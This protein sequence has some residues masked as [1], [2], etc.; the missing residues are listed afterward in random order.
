M[1]DQEFLSSIPHVPGVY[2]MLNK[3]STVLYVGKAKDLF[4]RLSSYLHFSGTDHSKTSVM[5]RQ[6]SKIDTLMTNTEKEALILES[7][8]IKK[9][10]PKYNVI[11]RD[12]KS[13]PFIKVTV[14]EEW[15][16]VFMTRRKKRDGARYFGPYSSSS[17]MWSTLKLL[18]SLFPLRRCKGAKL[19]PRKRPCLNHQMN[20]CLA[21]CAGKADMGQ[22]QDMVDKVIMFMEGRNKPLLKNLKKEMIR[23][24]ELEDFEKAALLRDR[25]GALDKTLEKQIVLSKTQKDRDVFGFYRQGVSVSVAL[26]YVRKGILGGSRRFFLEDPYGDDKAILSQVIKQLYD[27][28]N[29][30]PAELLLPHDFEDRVVMAERLSDLSER[31]IT[32][33]VPQRGEPKELVHMAR[34]NA[35]QLFDEQQNKKR[36]WQNLAENIQKKLHLPVLPHRI[37]CLDISNISGTNAVGSLVSFYSGEPDPKSYRHYKIKTVTGPDDYAMMREVIH[38][39]FS[40]ALTDNDLPD[41]FMVDGGR[42]QLGVAEAVASD[43]KLAEMVNLIGIAKEREDEGEKLYRPGR[44]NPIILPSHSPLLLYLMRIR[45][46]SHRFGVTFH[47]SLRRKQ[48]FTSTLDQIPGVGEER[49]KELLRTIGSLQKVSRASIEDLK[50]VAGIGPALAHEIHQFFNQ[51]DTDV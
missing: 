10:R 38:R 44:K 22:Y 40:R 17:A 28:S 49:K 3:A 33:S 48:T 30:P 16:R 7:S 14:Q 31:I 50:N 12:D 32:L 27:E 36:S 24:A 5:L 13:Y 2:L 41:L 39:R 11:L 47:R 35:K 4:K 9:H 18:F 26:L 51:I 29:F 37:E 6:V 43:L 46:E 8:L 1:L 34:T 21:P 23:A 20:N 45:D 42:G 25:I 19:K 15:P